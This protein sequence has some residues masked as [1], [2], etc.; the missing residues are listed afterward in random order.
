MRRCF[1]SSSTRMDDFPLSLQW[2]GRGANANFWP[3]E[4]PHSAHLCTFS[5][6][7]ILYIFLEWQLDQM[8]SY[9]WSKCWLWFHCGWVCAF[10]EYQLDQIT[11]GSGHNSMPLYSCGIQCA[12]PDFLL[13]QM[14]SHILNKFSS[15]LLSIQTVSNLGLASASCVD[16]VALLNATFH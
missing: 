4:S 13:D 9:Y 8:T 5:L 2:C 14:T 7:S 16:L 15:L 12:S 10:T 3:N 11:S 1:F 6:V